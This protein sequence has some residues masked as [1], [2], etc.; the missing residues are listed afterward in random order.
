MGYRRHMNEEPNE[1][2]G[3]MD[4]S[5]AEHAQRVAA[6]VTAEAAG[7]TA[8]NLADDRLKGMSDPPCGVT[9]PGG[10]AWEQLQDCVHGEGSSSGLRVFVLIDDARL[11]RPLPDRS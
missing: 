11:L 10:P 5:A 9:G 1:N 2:T 7:D 6:Q 4:G 8:W 3:S